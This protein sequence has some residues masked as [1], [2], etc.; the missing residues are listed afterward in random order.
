MANLNLSQFT[1]KTLVAD[2]DWVFVWD[3][4]NSISKKVSRNSLLNSG[5]LATSAP[6][7]VSQTWNAGTNVMTALK[8]V[9]TDTASG[10]TSNLLELWSGSTAALKLSV[11][12]GGQILGVGG[13]SSVP[14]Y[15]FAGDATTGIYSTNSG[16]IYFVGGGTVYAK[17]AG[18]LTQAADQPIRWAATIDAAG[19]V[20]LFR[21]AANTLALRNGAAAQTFRVYNTFPGNG[22]N[23]FGSFNW[24]DQ[25]NEFQIATGQ[26]GT[27]T[28]RALCLR[29]Q[30]GLNIRIGSAPGTLVWQVGMSTGH[31]L[32]GS[33]NT[34]DIGA[35]NANRPRNVF[36]AQTVKA[37]A[38]QL[39]GQSHVYST[40]NGDIGLY[41]NALTNFNLL[42]FGGTS[43]SYP[44]I[45]RSST[46]LQARLANDS[47]FAPIQGK[48]TTDTAY[49]N[50]VVAATTGYITIYDST[51]TAYRVP[52]VV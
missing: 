30:G 37:N 2:A 19:D 15:S 34:Y 1:E 50:T 40:V 4:A 7:T 21:D 51:G 10:A 22:N 43:A 39:N 9:A 13:S 42:Q 23:E 48:L 17:F 20:Y 32:A 12:K 8:V 3:T 41:D 11:R 5:T 28:S 52:C 35:N 36:V 29:G 31:F 47:A 45:K 49:T 24:V 18:G 16:Q 6:V 33:D 44:A 14:T 27:G 38:F 26:A 25:A 46:T